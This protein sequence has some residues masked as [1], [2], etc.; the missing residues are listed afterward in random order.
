TEVRN[1]IKEA[2]D[3]GAEVLTGS[4][5]ASPETAKGFYP[6]PVI[7]TGVDNSWRVCKEEV[8]GPVLVALPWEQEEEV[9]QWAN[10]TVYG[11]AAYVFTNDLTTA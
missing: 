8:F 5:P 10:D 3:S 1:F 7:V 11:L 4:V 2:I 9:I 6:E